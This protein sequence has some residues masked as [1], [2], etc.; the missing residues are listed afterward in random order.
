MT[1]AQR[2]AHLDRTQTNLEALLPATV[3]IDGQE[4]E[5]AGGDLSLVGQTLGAAGFTQDVTVAFRIRKS[6]F[7]PQVPPG[8]GDILTY[9][10]NDYAVSKILPQ[11]NDVA[12]YIGCGPVVQ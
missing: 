5:C 3:T 10:G 12:Y 8:P 7:S 1:A 6:L 2:L 4:Y 9:D 11:R